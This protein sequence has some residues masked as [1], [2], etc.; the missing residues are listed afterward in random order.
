[1]RITRHRTLI[2]GLLAGAA[3]AGVPAAASGD[4]VTGLTLHSCFGDAPGCV[5]V[6]G[7]PLV[8]ANGVAVSPNGSVYVSGEST[9]APFRG[10]VSHLFGGAAGAMSYDG[11]VSDDGD[12]GAC[13]DVPGTGKPLESAAGVAVS[14]NGRSVYVITFAGIA[15]HLFADATGGQLTWDGCIS[16]DG[17]GGTCADAGTPGD[18]NPF[19]AA[20]SIAVSPL[21]SAPNASVYFI[22][23]GG[24]SLAHM[25]ADP[26]QGQ[27]NWDGCVSGI[28]EDPNCADVAA[29]GTN[30]L[31][32]LFRL[33]VNPAGTAVYATNTSGIVDQ[34][35]A[36]PSAGG[37]L[38]SFVGCRNSAGSG[39]CAQ[40][41]TVGDPLA[42]AQGIA[43]SPDGS[44]VYVASPS[45]GT[46]SHFFADP[47]GQMLLSWDGCISNDGS[48]G[49]CAK[50]PQTGTPLAGALALAVSPDGHTLY[51]ISRTQSSLSWFAIAPQGQLTYEGCLSDAAIPGCTDP[52]GQPLLGARAVAI[53]PDSGTVYVASTTG[54]TIASF[55]VQ[56]GG[57]GG[58]GSPS[59]SGGPGGSGGSGGSGASGGPGHGSQR[60]IGLTCTPPR[61]HAHTRVTLTCRVTF[62]NRPIH[63]ATVRFDHRSGTTNRRGFVQFTVRLAHRTY[64]AT[65]TATGLPGTSIAIHPRRR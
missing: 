57:T 26:Q 23:T 47:T 22:G 32:N 20:D 2:V 64:L 14:P 55:A 5:N 4:P 65:A 6:A 62:R 37:G 48:G 51:A 12:G 34:F 61:P 31:G 49:A 10:F 9:T 58:S 19:L 17:S 11:C 16:A 27:L 33:A 45:A 50:G 15:D 53:S 60:H 44:S 21:A 41:A 43:V 54:S 36:S 56:T 40:G 24:G 13:A 38:T 25:F 7:D 18:P 52:A 1:M 35:A 42:G 28:P 39:G 46:V 59:G 3:I 30:P 29:P 8:N 63:G